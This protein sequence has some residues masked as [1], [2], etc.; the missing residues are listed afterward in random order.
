MEP[1]MQA[2]FEGERTEDELLA[3]TIARAAEALNGALKAAALKGVRCEISVNDASLPLSL[4][5]A[6]TMGAVVPRQVYT[7]CY[8]REEVRSVFYIRNTTTCRVPPEGWYCTRKPEHDG[9]CAALPD[10]RKQTAE[11]WPVHPDRRAGA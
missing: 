2:P 3:G 10:R 1:G 11:A 6:R 5:A 8:R 9:P 7:N 4:E